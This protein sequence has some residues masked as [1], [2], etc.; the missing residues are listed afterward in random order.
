MYADGV[1]ERF[2]ELAALQVHPDMLNTVNVETGKVLQQKLGGNAT[3]RDFY[4]YVEETLRT[5]QSYWIPA[6]EGDD[7]VGYMPHAFF[8]QKGM[9]LVNRDT[10][11]RYTIEE[12]T[13]N[14]L[15]GG[16]TG[17]VRLSGE[18]APEVTDVL[19]LEGKDRIR[20]SRVS[21]RGDDI[22]FEADATRK[23]TPLPWNAYIDFAV[24]SEKPA[25][26]KPGSPRPIVMGRKRMLRE[27]IDVGD[28]PSVAHEIRGQW[29]DAVVRFDLWGA[30]EDQAEALVYWFYKYLRLNAWVLK[31]NGVP[32][33]HFLRRGM[34]QPIG[35]WR[36]NL[37]HRAIDLFVRTE[38]LFTSRWRKLEHITLY[39]RTRQLKVLEDANLPRTGRPVFAGAEIPVTFTPTEA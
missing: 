33:F 6:E 12:V 23:A 11:A 3:L 24:V 27:I 15:T 25:E 13:I 4:N 36:T 29:L 35:K 26:S 21:K 17:Q 10:K 14:A 2:D 19:E 34:D 37:Y 28:E 38:H 5:F 39:A 1:L 30:T 31:L 7:Y 9:N 8:L 32:E 16:P 20:Y 18:T 22:D